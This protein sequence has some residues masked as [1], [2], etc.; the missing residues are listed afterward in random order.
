[1]F[2]KSKLQ[3]IISL[4]NMIAMARISIDKLLVEIFTG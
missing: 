2:L 4:M 1:M 3:V